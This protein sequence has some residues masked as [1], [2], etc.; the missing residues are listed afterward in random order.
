MRPALRLLAAALPALPLLAAPARAQRPNLVVVVADDMGW[1]EA[2]PYGHPT[3]RTPNLARLAR[4]GLRFDRAFVTTSSCSPSRASILT[5]RY[6]HATGA[7]S[8]HAPVP[9]SQ[10]TF[11]ELLRRA[12]YWTASVG[13]WHLG[14]ALVG[15]FDVV[16]DAAR[17]DA[18]ALTAAQRVPFA[19]PR[20]AEELYD[21]RADPQELHD[22]AGDPRYAAVQRSLGRAL[23]AWTRETADRRPAAR[24]PPDGF[25]RETG[26]PLPRRTSGVSR[27]RGAAPR[28]ARAAG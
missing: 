15:R 3:V 22:L 2:T 21:T 12:G 19:L 6:P 25:D 13:K 27:P 4:E 26:E 8:L 28:S 10:V 1:D 14:D 23:D 17:R 16:K 9:A 11:V 18:G 5:G 7:E 20:P 24:T